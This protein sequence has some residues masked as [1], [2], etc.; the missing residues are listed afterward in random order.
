[1]RTF[2][3]VSVV[4]SVVFFFA[5]GN[6][7]SQCSQPPAPPSASVSSV[8]CGQSATITASGSSGSYRWYSQ[9]SGG[10]PLATGVTYTTPAIFASSVIYYVEAFDPGS[11]TCASGRVAVLVNTQ[12]T[13]SPPSA[14][15]STVACGSS[16][17]LN[18]SGSTGHYRWY[19]SAQGGAP[20]SNS[21]SYTYTPSNS[22]TLYLEA[23]SVNP[24]GSSTFSFTGGV[25]TWTVPQGVT[26]ISVDIRGARGGQGYNTISGYSEGGMGGR[27]QAVIPVTPGEVLN[28]YVGGQ[29][30]NGTS[31][32]GT[33]AGGYNGGGSGY[34]RA[35][36]G[37]GASDMRRGGTG[38]ADRIIVAGGG[39]GGSYNCNTYNQQRGGHGGGLTGGA[40][41]YCNTENPCY[42]GMG[43]T[44]T[45]GGTNSTCNYGGTATLG[46]GFS[47]CCSV[48]SGGG[49]GGYYGG[50]GGWYAGGGGGSSYTSPGS[51]NV[52]HTQGFQNGNGQVFIQYEVQHC[53]SVRVPVVVP[54][55]PLSLPVAPSITAACASSPVLTATGDPGASFSWFADAGLTQ[56]E[57]NGASFQLPLLNDSAT[58][59]VVSN[60]Q[61]ASKDTFLFTGSAQTF[62][63]PAGIT[64]INVELFGAQ[65]GNGV[66]TNPGGRGGS[67]S[68]ILSVT[69]GEV[70]QVNV[71]GTTSNWQGGWN[72]GGNANSSYSQSRG[73]G[74][75]S[76]IRSG[77]TALTNRIITA[78]GGGGGGLDC[79]NG[80]DGGH[81]G[82]SS[83][84]GTGSYC[85]SVNTNYGGSGASPNAGGAG[86]NWGC[87][88]TTATGS[89]GV[90]GI[91]GN[92]GE[93]GG[94][95]GGGQFGG[96]GGYYGGGGGGSSYADPQRAV[97]VV[98]AQGVRNG[99]GM[100]IIEYNLSICQTAAVPVNA[101]ATQITWQ[102]LVNDTASCGGNA[103]LTA[104]P[105]GGT[106]SWYDNPNSTTPLFQGVSLVQL[107]QTQ[108]KTYYVQSKSSTTL[109][110]S[111]IYSFTGAVQTFVVPAGVSSMEVE[112]NGAQGG[113]GIN[114]ANFGGLGGMVRATLS[115][116]PGET[117]HVYVGGTSATWQGGWNGGGDANLNYSQGRGG[118]GGTDIR[119]GGTALTNRI[120]TA[121]GGGGGGWSCSTGQ[122]GG[123]G[124]G[125]GTAGTGW[126]CGG[127]NTCYGGLGASPTQGGNGAQCGCGGNNGTLGLGG[128]GGTCWEYGGGGGGG[129]YGGGGG[130]YGGGG[131]GSS[132]ASPSRTSNVVH[133]QG[134]NSGNG[135]VI[136]R[137]QNTYSCSSPIATVELVIDSLPAPSVSPDALGCAPVTH[138]FTASGG[139]P[140]YF[141]Y[142]TESGSGSLLGTG[143][144]YT[145]TAIDTSSYYVGYEDP[146]GCPSKRAKAS[147]LAQPQ[148]DVSI[149]PGF[150]SI[151]DNVASVNLQAATPGG[152][153]TGT[154]ITDAVLGTFDVNIAG[155]G[156]ASVSYSVVVNGCGNT[157]NHTIMVNPNPDASIITAPLAICENAALQTLASLQPGGVWSGNGLSTAGDFDPALVT[158]GAYMGYYQ[159]TTTEGCTD[160][161]SLSIIVNALPDPTISGIPSEVC[162]TGSSVLLSAGTAGGT[163]SGQGINAQTGLFNPSIAGS[164]SHAVAYIVT[165]NGC[166]DSATATINVVSGPI[167][168]ILAAP[169]TICENASSIQ[170]LAQTSGGTWSGPGITNNTTGIF[171]PSLPATGSL[172]VYYTITQGNCSAVD[173]AQIMVASV[174]QVSLSPN[175]AQAVC[176]G[177]TVTFTASGGASYQWMLNG[178]PIAG[179]T[180]NT[181]A[182]ANSGNYQVQVLNASNCSSTSTPVGL[183]VQPK[184]V[185]SNVVA[186][187]VCQG[188]ST[189]FSASANVA[190]TNGAVVNS[191]NWDF[192]GQGTG[193]LSQTS[194]SFSAAGSFPV[195]LIVGTNQGCLDTFTVQALVNPLP[196]I[197]SVTASSACLGELSLF[198]AQSAVNP[199]NGA[200]VQNQSW[201]FGNGV[202]ASG[203]SV[204]N[205]Y[206][207]PGTYPYQY[208]VTSNHGCASTA[209]GMANVFNMPTALFSA[210]GNCE[211]ST[212][213]FLNL[214]SSNAV[215]WAWDF[216]DGNTSLSQHPT[217]SYQSSGNFVVSLTA[218][219]AQGCSSS[220]S[221]ILPIAP[222]PLSAFSQTPYGGLSYQFSPNSLTAGGQYVW[223]FGDGSAS[224]D[225]APLKT[226]MQ[227]G[228]YNVC[229]TISHNGC[230][231]KTCQM[232]SI[233]D[234]MSTDIMTAS[235]LLVFPNPF[236]SQVSLSFL[237]PES[238]AVAVTLYD[239]A[240]RRIMSQDFGH[241]DIGEVQ[242]N[243]DFASHGLSTGM[244]LLDV[245]IGAISIPVRLIKQ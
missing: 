85:S 3:I 76:D 154:G 147:I 71:G 47:P 86:A 74:G 204:S 81:G 141:W 63:V 142:A 23:T 44:Q 59:Y 105:S 109:P 114:N 19:S 13:V 244:Y 134:A 238:E 100:I 125:S 138:T 117:L 89:L 26:S 80:Q 201:Q 36:G 51:T 11:P 203:S 9:S 128:T 243:L 171:D 6:I 152:T 209:T 230:S 163:W 77:G 191:Y 167:P 208:T 90:G 170:L 110:D 78:G 33:F 197:S 50:G 164:G 145:G 227:A 31:G 97:N 241:R 8:N 2:T 54:V 182:T 225:I 92:C 104:L 107:A 207:Q 53:T 212:L 181:Y 188:S 240:G 224:T 159:I 221:Q 232:V 219:T 118:G 68:A 173:S 195:T 192:A 10:S 4:A 83:T 64:S 67:V 161:D 1:M 146:G 106:V 116:T 139:L 17:T 155:L 73:G 184:P 233:T 226:Y 112:L 111:S 88:M 37:G 12:S 60:K 131:G 91:G 180:G 95:G 29:G 165:Q 183:T 14:S 52:T 178:T 24:A 93:Y 99:A 5:T 172:M 130:Y 237:L 7:H 177:N 236:E 72:G 41:L 84:A 66:N 160:M 61:V 124:G 194:F 101:V 42:S 135:S 38:L 94:G 205:L 156:A 96:G 35:G 27:V 245:Q 217:H 211:G 133:N 32:T 162:N 123:A 56:L 70:L 190:G 82:G 223:T 158:P 185:I 136:F 242:L 79:T 198:N 216:G 187:S 40:G 210:N 28:I 150:N 214:S 108:S 132:F 75:A 231:S 55:I 18:A 20:I 199:I 127:S 113:N 119:S 103:Q 200:V 43:G 15:G 87:N 228:N 175:N 129:H 46:N 62:T 186:S 153:W 206:N 144:T 45:A 65:G 222:G 137:W 120:I 196:V 149:L 166:S 239:L 215:S 179:A 169:A 22:D 16:V 49:G 213:P 220:Y 202:S 229:L 140:N 115:V 98:H 235:E 168:T 126:E 218:N 34:Y 122:N 48:Y 69:P 151:C 102:S 157:A 25:Q 148:P 121:G 39:G 21:A 30:T 57:G 174:P 143:A 176:E 189:Q 193:A 234:Q 58:Y